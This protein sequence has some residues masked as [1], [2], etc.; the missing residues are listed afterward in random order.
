VNLDAYFARIGWS[1][2]P[3]IPGLLEHHMRAIPFENFDVLLGQPPKLDADALE[4]KLVTRRRGGYCYEHSTLFAEV[5]RE[6]GFP[7]R[8]HSARVVMMTPRENSPR[9]HMFLSVGYDVL[10]PGFGGMAPRVPIR[11]GGSAGNHRIAREGTDGAL[12]IKQGDEWKRLWISTFERDNPID[13]VMANHFTAT[14][15]LSPFTQR[16]M[17]RAFTPDGQVTIANRDVT[18]T[19]NGEAQTRPL[20]DRA[21]LRAVVREYWGFDLPELETIRVPAI[22]DWK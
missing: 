2:E 5:L 20:A 13:F 4:D 16:I 1:G 3:T 7:V 14:H 17:A 15:P 21:E 19:K 18:I 12:E 11:I 9:T 6:L 10:D 8:M 22:P